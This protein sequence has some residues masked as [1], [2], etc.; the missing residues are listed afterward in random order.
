MENKAV[1]FDMDG[2]LIDSEFYWMKMEGKFFRTLIPEFQDSDT[3]KIV[4]N[5]INGTYLY[6]KDKFKV[7]FSLEDMKNKYIDFGI[8]NIYK[9]VNLYDGVYN[10]IEQEKEKGKLISLAS[11]SCY[12]WI[13][14]ALDKL[15]VR[16]L[17]DVIVSSD[18]CNG[19]GKPKSDI[20]LLALKNLNLNNEDCIIIEDSYNGVLAANRANI[21][22][23]GFRNGVNDNQ[24]L[25]GATVIFDNFSNLSVD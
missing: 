2:V 25:S 11:S 21:K 17:F 15:K 6:L 13:N 3:K 16:S 7:N 20:F 4:G 5:S 23:F 24:D 19:I 9:N 10:F 14:Y 22:A 8:E 1:I 18:D 12:P